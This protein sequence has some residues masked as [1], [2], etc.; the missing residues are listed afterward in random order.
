MVSSLI[1]N[2]NSQSQYQAN[3][4]TNRPNLVKVLVEDEIDVVVWQ[5]ILTRLHPTLS[6]EVTPYSK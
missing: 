5:K 3:L 6:Y 4:L 2:Q 1:S